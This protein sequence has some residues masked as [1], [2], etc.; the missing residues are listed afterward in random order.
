MLRTWSSHPFNTALP[1]NALR[2]LAP[3]I[4]QFSRSF[5]IFCFH[6]PAP[7][8]AFFTS[9]GNYWFLRIMHNLGT[10]PHDEGEDI[11]SRL[12]PK[13][14]AESMCMST[15]PALPQ[16]LDQPV[17]GPTGRYGESVRRR[18]KDRGMSEKIR[19]YREGLFMGR[20]EKSLE[21][22]AALFE[23]R[24]GN[25]RTSD[26]APRGA[27]KA[28]ATLVL[29]ER[30][31]AFDLRL[32]LENI[33]DYLVKGSQVLVVKEAGHWMPTEP[34]A[35]VV[36]EQLVLWALSAEASAG[37]ATPFA[38]MINVKVVEEV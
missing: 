29:G 28:P 5:Y 26:A 10:G 6:L 37:K 23:L 24:S 12:D 9:F 33:R 14:A 16:L 19:I 35:R 25:D 30:D 8:D 21:T 4:S 17:G 15:G 34:T 13:T 2:A 18:I 31:P 7:L 36:L 11:L 32:A 22:T 38:G 1:K 20:W 3:V 27:L